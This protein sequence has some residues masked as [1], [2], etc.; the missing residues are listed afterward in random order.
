MSDDKIITDAPKPTTEPSVETE[1]NA[2]KAAAGGGILATL[3]GLFSRLGASFGLKG[4]LGKTASNAMDDAPAT[5]APK[6]EKIGEAI[7]DA[8][9]G[10]PQEAI[11]NAKEQASKVAQGLAGKLKSDNALVN[12]G[13]MVGGA[14]GALDGARRLKGGLKKDE[15][16]KRNLKQVFAGA[17]ETS[18]GAAL[19]I[20]KFQQQR[21]GEGLSIGKFTDMVGRGKSNAPEASR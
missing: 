10:K 16:G 9:K 4:L 3:T 20:S 11:G 21:G 2:G 19:A 18:L 13:A 5:D 7:G 12:K 6:T 17:V 14:V 1:V 15:N 8:V